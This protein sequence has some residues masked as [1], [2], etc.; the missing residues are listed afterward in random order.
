MSTLWFVLF[1]LLFVVFGFLA[2]KVPF[3]SGWNSAVS[4]NRIQ[5]MPIEFLRL[6]R[7]DLMKIH[8]HSQCF[9]FILFSFFLTLQSEMFPP[10]TEWCRIRLKWHFVVIHYIGFDVPL[11]IL[12]LRPR[13]YTQ[14]F[15][16][17]ENI[18]SSFISDRFM[19]WESAPQ[20]LP[21]FCESFFVVANER[22]DVFT[23]V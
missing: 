15:I 14:V 22:A 13:L 16:L 5:W 9:F 12:V 20:V 21:D 11:I 7:K 18:P 19:R 23:Y 6:E 17:L 1:F 3:G 10:Q 2:G 8:L 4:M